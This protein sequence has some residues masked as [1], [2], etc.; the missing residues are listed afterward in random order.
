M[1]LS[2]DEDIFSGFFRILLEEAKLPQQPQRDLGNERYEFHLDLSI[3]VLPGKLLESNGALPF[4]PTRATAWLNVMMIGDWARAANRNK[5]AAAMA[6][7]AR[8]RMR[9]VMRAAFSYNYR[10]LKESRILP[11]LLLLSDE[12]HRLHL[13]SRTIR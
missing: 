12:P 5:I 6:A 2:K 10:K 11:P 7:S 9:A 8:I 4:G 1:S 3:R 13:R